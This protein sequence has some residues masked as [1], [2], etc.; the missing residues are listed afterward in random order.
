MHLYNGLKS[1]LFAVTIVMAASAAAAQTAQITAI[2]AGR[3]FDPKS[4]I[5]LQNQ[6]ILIS[7]DRIT[8][9]GRKPSTN[10]TR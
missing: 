4:G 1:P 7:G 10:Q 3:L 6:V 2:K 9:V 5:D 8:D